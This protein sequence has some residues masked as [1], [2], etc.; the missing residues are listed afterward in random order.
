MEESKARDGFGGRD[1]LERLPVSLIE[2]G[3]L[4]SRKRQ[5]KQ[6]QVVMGKKKTIVVYS[7]E[8][9]GNKLLKC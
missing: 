1:N 5:N 3:H 9:T 4:H 2:T 6:K 8:M 7:I